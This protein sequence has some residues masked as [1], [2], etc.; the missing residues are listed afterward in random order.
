MSRHFTAQHTASGYSAMGKSLK[1]PTIAGGTKSRGSIAAAIESERRKAA[2]M[3]AAKGK[4][5]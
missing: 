1:R 3:Q 2:R 4:K 5:K